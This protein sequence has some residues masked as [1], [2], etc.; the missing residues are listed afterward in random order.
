[1]RVLCDTKSLSLSMLP[2]F[3]FGHNICFHLLQRKK[4][5]YGF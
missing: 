2:F 5:G 4:Q 3:F 1:L